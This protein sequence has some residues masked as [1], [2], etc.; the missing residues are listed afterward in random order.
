MMLAHTKKKKGERERQKERE[1]EKA[2]QK[3]CPP[4]PLLPQSRKYG[5]FPLVHVSILRF[6]EVQQKDA[7]L[8]SQL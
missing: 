6:V 4:V 1:R 8:V 5:V 2:Y 7:K 3:V